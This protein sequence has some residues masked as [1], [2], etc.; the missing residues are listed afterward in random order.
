ML[1]AKSYEANGENFV[2]LAIRI[3]TT[4][5]LSNQDAELQV[6]RDLRDHTLEWNRMMGITYQKKS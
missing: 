3:N 5:K 2:D 1:N 4:R 6:Y